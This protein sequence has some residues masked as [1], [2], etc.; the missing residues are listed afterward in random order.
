MPTI[1]NIR[2]PNASR[3]RIVSIELRKEANMCRPVHQSTAP[4]GRAGR[5]LAVFLLTLHDEWRVRRQVASAQMLDGASLRDIG[6][7]SGG[8]ESAIRHGRER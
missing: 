3:D 6:L 7:A 4:T 5:R 8:V 2:F 1:I